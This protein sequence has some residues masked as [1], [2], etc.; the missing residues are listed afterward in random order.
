MLPALVPKEVL[1][2]GALALYGVGTATGAVTFNSLLQAET[3]EQVRGRVFASMD[4][5]WQ[6]GCLV[7]LGLGGV[8]ADLYGIETV[9]YVGGAFPLVAATAGLVSTRS[10]PSGGPTGG[11]QPP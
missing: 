9:Y 8:L 4:V 3:P 7:S 2:A 5:L 11:L 6:S 10:R 1:V